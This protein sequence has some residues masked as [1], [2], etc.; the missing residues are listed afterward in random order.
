MTWMDR[1][2]E[3]AYNSPSGTRLK[4]NYEDVS[5]SFTK[6][7]TAFQFRGQKKTYIQESGVTSA[8]IPLRVYFF[9]DDY[10]KESSTFESMI[11]EPGIGKI[12][13]PI[14]GTLNVVPF[15]RITRRDDLKTAA[16]QSIFD[17]IFWESIGVLYPQSR[18]DPSSDVV[19][20]IGSYNTAASNE[21]SESLD[22]DSVTDQANAKN[23]YTFLLNNA[24]EGLEKIASAQEDVEQQF[25]AIYSS[26]NNGINILIGQPLTLAF[27]TT[28]L[29]QSPARALTS[30]QAR[31]NAYKDLASSIISGN[32]AAS[33][34]S[35]KANASNEFRVNNLYASSYLA[36][37]ILSAVNNEFFTKTDALSAAD[38]ILG[39]FNDVA[40]WQDDNFQSLG[41]IDTGAAYQQLQDAVAICTGFLVE[42][43]FSLNLE[44]SI[45]TDRDRTIIDLSAELYSDIDEKLSFLINTNNFSGSEL[46]MVPAGREIVYYA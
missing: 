39:Q 5:K 37:S 3:A 2:S 18:S 23:N 21:F 15:G 6:T 7:G 12:E 10:D 38:D 14:Y 1:I 13:H 30:I 40:A 34:S 31:L 27:Q 32:G 45:I 33:S 29:L 19:A 8:K 43:S 25:N 26:I 20:A 28:L 16:N 11:S 22:I 9:G 4:I 17:I 36:G 46:L 44:R 42:I 24:K 41:E 35:T